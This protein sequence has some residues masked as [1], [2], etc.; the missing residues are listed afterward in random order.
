MRRCSL[1]YMN[2]AWTWSPEWTSGRGWL[3]NWALGCGPWKVCYSE[4]DVRELLCCGPERM[5]LDFLRLGKRCS[6]FPRLLVMPVFR[7]FY[8]FPAAPLASCPS[9]R[10]G[11]WVLMFSS[12]IPALEREFHS[13]LYFIIIIF[14][15]VRKIGPE[16]TSVA[17]LPLF[18]WGRLWL[19]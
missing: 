7:S 8:G 14:F 11:L 2:T 3:W 6:P 5:K 10:P 1:R 15:L 4:W 12:V 9:T 13:F 19:S 17:N 16:L 18:A